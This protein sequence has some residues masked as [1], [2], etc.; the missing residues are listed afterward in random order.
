M[1]ETVFFEYLNVVS[2]FQS[3]IAELQTQVAV[4]TCL[5]INI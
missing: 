4:N 2:N 1:F 5:L 3:A